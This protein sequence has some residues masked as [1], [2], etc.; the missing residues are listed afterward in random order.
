MNTEQRIQQA[1]IRLVLQQGYDK[2]TMEDIAQDAG[3]ARSTIYTKWKTKEVLF[4]SVLRAEAI[5]LAQKWY[6]FVE[7]DPDGGT[8]TGIYKN[9]LL[10]IQDNAF[11]RALYTQDR[12]VLGSF[13]NQ[14]QIAQL[15]ADRLQWL[16][17]LL[18]KMQDAG[19]IRSDLDVH[20]TA[21]TA[22]IFRHGLLTISADPATQSQTSY[23][24]IVETFVTMFRQFVEPEA[25]PHASERGKQILRD[26]LEQFGREYTV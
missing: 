8:F 18:E 26:L 4:A 9:G 7:A 3:V 11:A 10:A 2:T 13:V 1:A 25:N 21:Q 12:R 14:P 20:A 17:R 24:Q 23:E 6:A 15:M 22:V 19:L 16:T 5:H